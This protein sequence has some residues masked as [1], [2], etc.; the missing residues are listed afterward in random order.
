VQNYQ[1]LVSIQLDAARSS[2]VVAGTVLSGQP[3]LVQVDK[4]WVDV[5]LA[6][7][8]MI[9]SYHRDRPGMIGH[10]GTLLGA[11]NVNISF[12]AVGRLAPKGEAL[13]VIGVDEPIEPDLV[14]RLLAV[15]DI[16]AIRTVRV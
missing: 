5:A 1:N 9:F 6:S 8:Q 14:E 11:A 10:V 13:M 15:P 2:R 16:H 3:H 12:M 7:G 4:Y